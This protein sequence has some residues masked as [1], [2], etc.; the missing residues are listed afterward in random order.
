MGDDGTVVHLAA[1][2]RD[3]DHAA[4]RDKLG[5]ILLFGELHRPDILVQHGLGGDDLAAVDH[6]AAT[7]GQDEVYLI[8]P[9]E[10][11][12]LLHLGVGGIGHDAAKL[13]HGLSRLG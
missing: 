12:A 13:H 2:A 1:G 9:A 6:T 7:H 8:L 4:H 5:G 3:G 11:C 10:P